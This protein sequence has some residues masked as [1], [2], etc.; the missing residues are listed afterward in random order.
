[1]NERQNEFELC[2]D[3]C[4]ATIGRRDGHDYGAYCPN[5]EKFLVVTSWIAIREGALSSDQKNYQIKLV[6]SDMSKDLIRSVAHFY[7][8]NF[9]QTK[10]W[11]DEGDFLVQAGKAIEI[12]ETIQKLVSMNIE[13]IIDPDFPWME[14]LD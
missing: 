2:P 13:H 10:K 3:C 11:L 1:M 5:C 14:Y 4:T 8:W 6:V 7:N 9:I 12:Y